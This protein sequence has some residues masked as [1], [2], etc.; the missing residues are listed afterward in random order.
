M[1]EGE[2]VPFAIIT[3]LSKRGDCST[4]IDSRAHLPVRSWYA[5]KE[6]SLTPSTIASTAELTEPGYGKAS[7]ASSRS[8]HT[9]SVSLFQTL[10]KHSQETLNSIH[11]R[12]RRFAFSR[13]RCSCERSRWRRGSCAS[14]QRLADHSHKLFT[15]G[16]EEHSLTVI[17]G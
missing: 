17:N 12:L 16:F 1:A 3:N 9:Q 2:R 5:A 7:S 8:S 14:A 15:W 11:Q 4:K 13:C 10:H 6:F